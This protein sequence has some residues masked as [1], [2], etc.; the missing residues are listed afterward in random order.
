MAVT[1]FIRKILKRKIF[2]LGS[3]VVFIAVGYYG[4]NYF[5]SD[6][7][8][9]RYVAATVGKGTLIVSVTG[10]GQVSAYNQIDVKP[11]VS[12]D[13]VY[14]GVK[15]GQEVKA[16]TLLV[17]LDASDAQKAV[18]DAETNLEAAKISLEKLKKPADQL[19]ILQAE[20]ALSQAKESKQNAED[21]LKKAYE[22]GFNVVSNAFLDLPDIMTKLYDILFGNSFEG[23]QVNIYYYADAVKIYDEKAN[24]YRDDAYNAYQAARKAY[25]KNFDDYKTATRYS[26][27]TQLEA[28]IDESYDTVKAISESIKSANNLIQFYKDKLTE[29][30]LKPSPKAD[31]ALS[32]LNGYT[33]KTNTH[34]LNLLNIKNTI[35][36]SRD[37]LASSNRSIAEKTEALAKLKAGAD[38]LDIR[39][40]EL[41]VKQREN[42]LLDAQEKL[43][44]YFIRAP[45]DGVIAKINAKRGDSVSAGTVVATLITKQRLAEISLNE[46]D[47]SKIKLGQKATLTFDAVE[48]LSI[49]GEVVE[50]DSVGTVSQG[51]VTYTVKISFD[52]QDERVK[53][54]MS[55]TAAIIVE[56]KPD[57]LLVPNSAI[58]SQ[59][60]TN[61]VEMPDESEVD[62]ALANSGGVILK[63]PLRRQLIE[64]GAA[65]DE[66][67]EVISGLSPGDAVITRTI[68][69]NQTQT[70]TLSAQ[71]GFRIPGLPG[72]GGG[73]RGGGLGR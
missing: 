21:N 48:G 59:G 31:I 16:G 7:G 53:P 57:V 68:Q 43:S 22:D 62:T 58:K 42:A 8:A 47:V 29:R 11:K 63:K 52:T 10:S 70:Q 33:G 55:V 30:G 61:Y 4:Y 38:E 46:V 24:Q 40:Q 13:I 49:S 56:A 67:T 25:D 28:L 5:F 14:V 26:D 34:L 15:N 36:N 9:I 2:V 65:N 72:G 6:K 66:F 64:I 69:P 32:D 41:A 39:A 23:S 73:F 19:S 1:N 17:Q 71:S 45:F 50:I 12:G 3:I 27:T 51:V 37:A 60:D 35:N 44:N 20:N 18:R 54:G